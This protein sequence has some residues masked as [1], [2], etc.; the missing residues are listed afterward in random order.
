MKF[1]GAV[2]FGRRYTCGETLEPGFHTLSTIGRLKLETTILVRWKR[3]YVTVSAIARVAVTR[4][5]TVLKMGLV[6]HVTIV[7]SQIEGSFG[8]D[9][10]AIRFQ[11]FVADSQRS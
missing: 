10:I 2:F 11:K 7:V 4:N 5:E 1:A 8:P 9:A 3:R 6:G